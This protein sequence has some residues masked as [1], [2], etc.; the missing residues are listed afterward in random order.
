[1]IRPV[2]HAG[3]GRRRNATRGVLS[4][5][6][7]GLLTSA[8]VHA[9]QPEAHGATSPKLSRAFIAPE[10]QVTPTQEATVSI[11]QNMARPYAAAS[12][13]QLRHPG[14]WEMRW[15]RRADRPNLIQGSGVPLVPGSGN[16]LT[17]E[18]MG[19][20]SGEAVDLAVVE[21]RLLDFVAA[22][23][24]LL[25]TDGL[26]FALDPQ[27]SVGYGKDNTHWFIEFAQTKNGVRVKGAN[28]FF[29]ISHGNIVQFG[30]HLVAPV[31]T[32]TIPVSQREKA[33]DMAFGELGMPA[34]TTVTE[35]LNQGELLVLPAA[36]ERSLE[37]EAS[38]NGARGT[39]YT[40]RLAWH[41]A[42]RVK[43]DA[44]TYDLF[45]DAKTNRVIEVRDL[46]SYVNATVDGGVFLGLNTGPE[47]IVPLPFAAVT[48]GTAKVTDALGIYDYSGG[49]ASVTLD[50]KYFRMSDACGSISLSNSTD[51]NLHLGTDPSTDCGS[52]TT[53]GAGNTRASRTGFYYLTKINRKA[54]T[55]L[56]SNSWIAGK[57]T[58]NMNVNQT[59]N[60]SWNGSSMNFYKS[61]T[62]PSDATIQCANT[63]ELPAVFRPVVQPA[64]HDA[65]SNMH[66]GG[67]P[68][69]TELTKASTLP[70]VS[71][72]I[73][74]AVA[75]LE[76]GA[77][78]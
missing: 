69:P 25:K 71:R 74:G 2:N 27:G 3:S 33:F 78:F 52:T 62:H 36:S 57:V 34:G 10:L 29:R 26:E 68:E 45:V 11:S 19:L 60:A 38:Y 20:R 65:R 30:T 4:S 43:D 17:V 41:F 18:S 1:M 46:T 21:A 24:D 40:H 72:Q 67:R 22:N 31:A 28:L 32:D 16:A 70:S 49:S 64:E 59:C 75:A 51:G 58:A 56:P 14:T 9:I 73:S 50:G 8:S 66:V 7:L 53:G 47:T 23:G 35:W 13:F 55:F 48:N 39:G 76:L 44:M 42:F 5:L 77:R 54:A 12:A 15:D 37:I 6:L 61:G 63:G